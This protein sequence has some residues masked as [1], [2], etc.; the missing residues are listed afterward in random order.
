MGSDLVAFATVLARSV[1]DKATREIGVGGWLPATVIGP[2]LN[3]TTGSL[4]G[5][6]VIHLDGDPAGVNVAASLLLT[7]EP[8]VGAR[9]MAFRDPPWGLY[10]MHLMERTPSGLQ[11]VARVSRVC[12]GG[13]G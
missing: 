3:S 11:M 13:G 4:A 2:E 1:T 7:Q 5:T 12:H 9:V 8:E 10:V 6:V